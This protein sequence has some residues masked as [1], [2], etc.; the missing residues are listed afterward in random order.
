MNMKTN[1]SAFGSVQLGVACAGAILLPGAFSCL[2]EVFLPVAI[3]I[4]QEMGE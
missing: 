1:R 3:A 4:D 2:E